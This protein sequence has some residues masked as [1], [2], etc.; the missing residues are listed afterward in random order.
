MGRLRGWWGRFWA[1]LE[2][3]DEDVDD[4]GLWLCTGAPGACARSR[5][6][7]SDRERPDDYE[8]DDGKPLGYPW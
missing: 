7:G 5:R 8:D 2:E 6:R 1:W 4:R 3:D